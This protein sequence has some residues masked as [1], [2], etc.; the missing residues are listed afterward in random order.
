MNRITQSIST[1]CRDQ[2]LAEKWLLAPSLRVGYQWLDRVARAGQ[3]VVNAHVKTL[4]SMALDLVGPILASRSLTLV[5]PRA[6]VLIIDRVIRKLSQ[7]QLDYLALAQPSAG[8]AET[9]LSSINA[10]RL[11]GLSATDL[12]RSCFEVSRKGDDLERLLTHYLELLEEEK[13]VDYAWVLQ[14]AAQQLESGASPLSADIQILVPEDLELTALETRLLASLSAQ[15]LHLEVDPVAVADA[16]DGCL[17]SDL[18]LCRWLTRAPEAPKP[19]E[20]DTVKMRQAV[21][22]V[23]EVRGVL[24]Y[25]LQHQL[26][27]DDVEVLHS[28]AECYVSLIY[29]AFSSLGEAGGELGEELPV[30]FAEGIPCWYSRPGRALLGWIQWTCQDCDQVELVRLVKEG[31]LQV[32]EADQENLDFVRLSKQI[33]GLGAG[34]GRDRFVPRIHR[35]QTVLRNRLAEDQDSLPADVEPLTPAARL[36][37]ERDVADLER[38]EKIVQSLIAVTPQANASQQQI[39]SA[40]VEYLESVARSVSRLDRFALQ[41]L[42]EELKDMAHWLGRGEGDSAIDIWEWLRVLPADSRV[43]G[44]TPRPGC[45]HVDSLV[46][47]GHSGRTTTFI[48]GLDDGRFPGSGIQDPLLLDSERHKLSEQLPTASRRREE[49]LESFARLLARLRG[50]LVL[51]FSCYG[52]TDDREMFPSPVLLT[53]FRLLSGNPERD[54]KELLSS[55][56]VA[57]SFAPAAS[58]ASLDMAEWWLWRLTEEDQVTNL[59]QFVDEQFPHLQEGRL[60]QQ[61]WLSEEFTPYDGLVPAAGADLDPTVADGPVMSANRL[62]T[63]G[64]C[65]RAFFFNY[66][67][68]LAPPDETVV[69]P[70]QWLDAMT[71]GL[72]LHELFEVFVRELVAE[73]RFPEVARDRD[74]LLELLNEQVEGYVERYPPVNEMTFQQE[75]ADMEQTALTF[76]REDEL[77][78][79]KHDCRPLYLEASLGMSPGEHGTPLDREEAIPVTLADG[80]TIHVRGRVDRIDQLGEEGL[81]NY[82]VWDYKTGSTWGF[83]EAQPFQ[84]GRKVQSFLYVAMVGHVIKQEIDPTAEVKHFGFFFPGTKAVGDRISWTPKQLAQGREILQNLCRV[85]VDG[86]FLA[87]ND[88]TDCRF[89]DYLPICGHE[90]E[91]LAQLKLDNPANDLLEPIRQLRAED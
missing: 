57:E 26:P 27:W 56:P 87:T 68:D 12:E 29:E 89:C 41:K 33:R 84:Q 78:C 20:D 62:Q 15:Q 90:V 44:S 6:A 53:L 46:R 2:L 55:L 77:F 86:A 52:V 35:Q 60:A 3:P 28:D 83:E 16:A 9:V 79:R 30:T 74:R 19:L 71:R 36:G 81:K 14:E 76:L 59:D 63:V 17:A 32:D 64:E 73:K 13:L 31:L 48:V 24:R 43:L 88:A 85:I 58:A 72:L 10:I 11:A 7:S 38:V 22:E 82:A 50:N 37:L 66:G 80:K 67:L 40:A 61:Q 1:V 18:E 5:S 47:G 8:L 4:A 45:L 75:R 65:P 25:C 51:S 91:S 69:D 70:D 42:V 49:R 34:F 54:Q 39:V 23:N 21:G